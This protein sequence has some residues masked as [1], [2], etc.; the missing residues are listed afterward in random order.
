[1]NGIRMILNAF[2]N[3]NA[4]LYDTEGWNNHFYAK[5]QDDMEGWNNHFYAKSQEDI[6][7]WNNHFYAF[8]NKIVTAQ[9]QLKQ[10]GRRDG[11]TYYVFFSFMTGEK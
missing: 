6:E 5:S 4:D 7:G 10:N 11:T 1:M 3:N 9:H 2:S 8:P